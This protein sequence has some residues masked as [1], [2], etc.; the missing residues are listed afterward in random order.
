ML[1]LEFR[2]SLFQGSLDC[3]LF[4]FRILNLL[5]NLPCQAFLFADLRTNTSLF[6][7]SELSSDKLFKVT[8]QLLDKRVFVLGGD[9]KANLS[10]E[11]NNIEQTLFRTGEIIGSELAANPGNVLFEITVRQITHLSLNISLSMIHRG[12]ISFHFAQLH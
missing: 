12:M 9:C 1:I 7:S 10:T 2:E 8:F 11:C 6:L 5:L 4:A 3:S